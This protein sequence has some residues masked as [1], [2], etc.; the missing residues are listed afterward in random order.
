MP[1]ACRTVY[2]L[3]VTAISAATDRQRERDH[4]NQQ[5]RLGDSRQVL[6]DQHALVEL[7]RRVEPAFFRDIFQSKAVGAAEETRGDRQTQVLTRIGELVDLV[8][9]RS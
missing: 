5:C 8:I 3:T 7:P 1:W 6:E 2:S 9:E 4:P